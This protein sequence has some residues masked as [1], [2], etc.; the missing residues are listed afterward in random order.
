MYKYKLLKPLYV[1][2]N[3]HAWLTYYIS[4]I[5]ALI[6]GHLIYPDIFFKYK[7]VKVNFILYL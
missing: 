2:L 1:W 3:E 5:G 4:S 7:I 6:M